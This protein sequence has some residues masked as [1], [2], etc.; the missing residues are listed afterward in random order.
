MKSSR[1]QFEDWFEKLIGCNVNHA[2]SIEMAEN[3]WRVWQASRAA[4]LIE[5][6]DVD[7]FES[8]YQFL[9]SVEECINSYG[10][11]SITK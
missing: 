10:V 1:E 7:D 5:L 11:R 8:T 9:F 3:Y 4:I 6:P 2:F